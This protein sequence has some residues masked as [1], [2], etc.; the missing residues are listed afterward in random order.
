MD[1]LTPLRSNDNVA[2]FSAHD[3]YL[4]ESLAD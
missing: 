2:K 1:Y 3:D 4:T